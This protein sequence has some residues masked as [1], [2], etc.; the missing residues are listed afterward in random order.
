MSDTVREIHTGF[1]SDRAELIIRCLLD[2]EQR[3]LASMKHTFKVNSMRY[4]NV[5]RAVDNE[6]VF[7]CEK[8][9][10]WRSNKS[11]FCGISDADALNHIA[12]CFKTCVLNQ[13]K[14]QLCSDDETRKNWNRSNDLNFRTSTTIHD[15]KVS[16]AYFIYDHLRQRKNAAKKYSKEMGDELIGLPLDPIMTEMKIGMLDEIERVMKECEEEKRKLYYDKEAA[17]KK[18][19][20]M[21]DAQC[22]ADR[23]A[24]DEAAIA[25][26]E[27]I[28]A[29]MAS[30]TLVA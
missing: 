3:R 7:T 24:L 26:V 20:E 22:Q 2:S 9:G 18:Y 1:Y 23:K 10:G 15:I 12:W 14:N 25:K 5:K 11:C 21:M 6:I 16:E 13:L 4:L 19:R 28:R 30:L 17:V 29:E 27:Q 8:F